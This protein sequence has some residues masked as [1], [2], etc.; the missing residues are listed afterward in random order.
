MGKTKKGSKGPG[1]DYWAR[2]PGNEGKCNSPGKGVKQL[3]HKRE[4]LQ[5][6]KE[7][8]KEI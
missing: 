4:R 2:R 7:D 3:T 8:N 5:Q 6:K 1:Y